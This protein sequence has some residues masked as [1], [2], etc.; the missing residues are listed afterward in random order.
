MASMSGAQ[1]REALAKYRERVRHGRLPRDLRDQATD[2]AQGRL[3]AGA[4]I[5]AVATELGVSE[6]RVGAWTAE[7]ARSAGPSRVGAF[8]AE[9][10]M[11]PLMV[12]PGPEP[13]GGARLEVSFPDG[14][15]LS[16]SGMAE[17]AVADTIIALRGP[18]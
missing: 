14:T 1:L 11:V 12:R 13:A 2:Y 9:V 8:S 6:A 10:A 16:V 17:R 4:A 3:R 18:R 5:S 7:G 15:K